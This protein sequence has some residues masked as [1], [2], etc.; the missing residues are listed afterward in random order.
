MITILAGTTCIVTQANRMYL[1]S[2]LNHRE[3]ALLYRGTRDGWRAIDFHSRCDDRGST[4][5]LLQIMNGDC[6]G[7]FTS[8]S[9][10]SVNYGNN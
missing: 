2:I 9:W 6:I 8:V 7:G 3:L 4:V 10:S 1:Q 5:V